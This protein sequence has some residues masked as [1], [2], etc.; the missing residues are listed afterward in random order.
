MSVCAHLESHNTVVSRLGQHRFPSVEV[1]RHHRR[2]ESSPQDIAARHAHLGLRCDG[3]GRRLD[4]P[5]RSEGRL[6]ARCIFQKH[7]GAV[8]DETVDVGTAQEAHGVEV[9]YG[10][11]RARLH[12]GGRALSHASA[13]RTEAAEGGRGRTGDDAHVPRERALE[14][15]QPEL[16]FLRF[17]ALRIDCLRDWSAP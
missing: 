15:G 4:Q 1:A 14:M 3:R 13:L 16:S 12:L 5:V 9:V 11:E 10:S 6:G 7:E 2:A 17:V 8:C